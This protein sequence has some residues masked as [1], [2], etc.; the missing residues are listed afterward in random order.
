[1]ELVPGVPLTKC[2]FNR[3]VDEER[4]ESPPRP[5]PVISDKS[6]TLQRTKYELIRYLLWITNVSVC[7]F[8][9]SNNSVKRMVRFSW[10][11]FKFMINL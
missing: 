6:V 3:P 8:A 7:L 4:A 1:M 10:R 5:R 11:A 2:V 9:D